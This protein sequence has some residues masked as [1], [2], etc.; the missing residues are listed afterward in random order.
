M[1]QNAEIVAIRHHPGTRREGSPPLE[2][3]TIHDYRR[4]FIK[5]GSGP[6]L[7]LIHGIGDNSDSWR[8][9]LDELAKDY[10]VIVPDLLG[11]GRSDK[12]R[13]DYSIAVCT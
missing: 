11:H 2:Y 12:P 10:T 8:T 1:V 3:V 9:V 6:A 5:T 4:A 7:L 13:A